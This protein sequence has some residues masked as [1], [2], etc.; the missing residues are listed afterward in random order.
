MSRLEVVLSTLSK[1]IQDVSDR[2]RVFEQ[3]EITPACRVEDMDSDG[4]HNGG[5]N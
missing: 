4:R 3:W 2:L 5:I 1:Q